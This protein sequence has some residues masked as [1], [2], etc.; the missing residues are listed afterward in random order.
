M[1]VRI[2]FIGFGEAGYFMAK[3]LK[4]EGL[5]GIKAFDVAQNLDGPYRRVLLDRVADAGAELAPSVEALVRDCS[6]VFCAVQAQYARNVAEEALPFLRPETIYADVT[7]AQPKQKQE[8]AALFAAK[9]L[10]YVDAAMMGSLP[11]DAH[12]VPMLCSG[13]GAEELCR[14]MNGHGMRMEFVTGPAGKA[15]T[16]KL[17]RSSFTKGVEA[18]SVETLLFAR[19]LGVEE[20]VLRSLGAGYAG[21]PFDERIVRLARSN[22]VHAERRAHEVEDCATLMEECGIT[23][24]M[25][26]AT[27]ERMRRSAKLGLRQELGGA[28]PKTAGEMY[29]LWDAKKY[30]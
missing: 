8:I 4:G 12:K 26:K 23:P 17:V 16:L 20:E 6:L 28:T 14:T 3:G 13:N 24:V 1:A 7:T 27:I 9:G 30:S 11:Q 18:L 22:M 15:S 2:G 10:G 21:T 5:Y 25:A 29:A 19:K